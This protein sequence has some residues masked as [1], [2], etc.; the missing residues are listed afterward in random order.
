MLIKTERNENF[1]TAYFGAYQGIWWSFNNFFEIKLLEVELPYGPE[2]P[3]VGCGGL[4]VRLVGLSSV[5]IS[6]QG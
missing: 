5:I 3:Y 1:K 6:L 2:C 4:D